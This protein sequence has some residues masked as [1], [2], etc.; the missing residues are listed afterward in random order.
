M[1]STVKTSPESS[2]VSG[3]GGVLAD[4][5]LDVRRHGGREEQHLPVLRELVE[6]AG[7]LLVEPLVQH[8]VGFVEDRRAAVLELEVLPADVVVDPAG[9][10]DDDRRAAL[11]RVLLLLH[12]RAAV[13]GGDLDVLVLGEVVDLGGHLERQLA[14]GAEDQ[15]R[16][17]FVLGVNLLEQGEPEGGGL[18]GAGL[19]ADDEVLA[20]R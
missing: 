18:P 5:V 19:A 13:D 7:D 15:R 10:A 17:A 14:G 8:L 2:S 11:Q 6:D 3:V 12:R 16:T 1:W 9:R 20:L 4:Q